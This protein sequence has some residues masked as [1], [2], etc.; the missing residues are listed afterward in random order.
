MAIQEM[1]CGTCAATVPYGRLSCPACGELLASVAGS[2]RVVVGAVTP[3]ATP[4]AL[5]DVDDAPPRSFAD[6]P[7]ASA[8]TV[9]NP[10][11]ELPWGTGRAVDGD[12]GEDPGGDMDAGAGAQGDLGDRA[13][14]GS[15]HEPGYGA[16]DEPGAGPAV[17]I[18]GDD[19]D[20]FGTNRSE[21]ARPSALDPAQS[22]NMAPAPGSHLFASSAPGAYV[23]R[24]AVAAMPAGPAAPARA[25]VGQISSTVDSEAST[26]TGATRAANL[27]EAARVV[28]F[29][30]WLSVAGG[31]LSAV[32]FLLPWSEFSVIGASGVGYFDR[33]G[34]AGPGHVIV[35]LGL[36]AFLALA[37]IR[38]PIPVWL[39]VGLPGL[40]LAALLLGLVWPY[41][42]GP[43]G[44]GV[45]VLI[46]AIGAALL[47]VAG[48]LA[49]VSDRH[50]GA[51]RAV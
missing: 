38:N 9:R 50:A 36:L 32:G 17:D 16:A 24:S 8:Q 21:Q 5:Y 12:A 13:A 15:G 7:L 34:M 35:V 18:D 26:A 25:W 23:P 29:A 51:D 6:Q 42:L 40:A 44:A 14:D 4:P 19:S 28:E 41:M 31:A 49:L 47:G 1:V 22:P 20:L 43:L 33:W 2:R 39:R 27:G 37:L 45:G 10:E 30:G 48:T 46:V 11:S 3:S